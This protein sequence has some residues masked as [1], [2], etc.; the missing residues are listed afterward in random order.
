[1]RGGGVGGLK[2]AAESGLDGARGEIGCIGGFA[3]CGAERG[4]FLV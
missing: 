3:G 1:M 4:A 2:A